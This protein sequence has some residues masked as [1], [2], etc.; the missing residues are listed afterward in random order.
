MTFTCH[1]GSSQGGLILRLQA[2]DY[3]CAVFLII[4]FLS[5][6]LTQFHCE[7]MAGITEIRLSVSPKCWD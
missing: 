6:F 7:A 5:L 4:V 2:N 1:M 3:L